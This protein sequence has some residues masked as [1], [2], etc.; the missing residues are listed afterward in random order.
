D[1]DR[2]GAIDGGKQALQIGDLRQIVEDDVGVARIFSQEVLMIV[3][4]AIECPARFDRGDDGRPEHVRRR[5]WLAPRSFDQP[6]ATGP[7]PRLYLAA[8]RRDL[9]P[10]RSAFRPSDQSRP[11]RSN[12]T[13]TIRMMPITPTPP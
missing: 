13:R 1:L 11:V 7:H 9:K 10:Q 2:L 4:G 3:L 6:A 12:M 8:D 5:R